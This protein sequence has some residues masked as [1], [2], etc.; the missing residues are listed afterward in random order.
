MFVSRPFSVDSACFHSAQIK[1]SFAQYPGL[2]LDHTVTY[3]AEELIAFMK[4]SITKAALD[5]HIRQQNKVLLFFFL[6]F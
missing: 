6:A 5:A 4:L 3:C 1:I 2:L